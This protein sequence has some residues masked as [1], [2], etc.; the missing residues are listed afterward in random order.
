MTDHENEPG[1]THIHQM[2]GDLNAVAIA[3]GVEG[4]GQERA[5]ALELIGQALEKQLSDTYFSIRQS[6]EKLHGF[7]KDLVSQGDETAIRDVTEIVSNKTLD[8][9]EIT[10]WYGTGSVGNSSLKLARLLYVYEQ[11]PRAA[12]LLV[13]NHI[14]G[15]HGSRSGSLWGVL[16]QGGLLSAEE[17]R[18]VGQRVSTGE[19]A[20]SPEG[21]QPTI[22]FADW[23]ASDSIRRY[24]GTAAAPMTVED[25]VRGKRELEDDYAENHAM[26]GDQ[27]PFTYNSKHLI[28]TAQAEIDFLREHP[29]SLEAQLLLANFPIAYGIDVSRYESME[30]YPE[31]VRA[32]KTK[33]TIVERVSDIDGEFM[34]FGGR[35]PLSGLPVI[36]VPAERIKEVAT[37][38][39]EHDRGVRVIDIDLLTAA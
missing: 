24:A 2:D 5:K 1:D 18:S 21:G 32:G 15:F 3:E 9:V 38:F 23:R 4:L 29:D 14:G 30:T 35:I 11:D 17:A 7:A 33:D 26:F 31:A 19:R 28:E 37:L 12:R 6:A 13:G 25:I 22:S 34:F 27:H 8:G 39:A 20:Y 10:K 16:T 36:A